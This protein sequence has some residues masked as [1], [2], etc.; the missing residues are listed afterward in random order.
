VRWPGAGSWAIPDKVRTDGTAVGTPLLKELRAI[1]VGRLGAT[2]ESLAAVRCEVPEHEPVGAGS[3]AGMDAT[4]KATLRCSTRRQRPV[5][6][7]P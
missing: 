5:A 2:E 6:G 7:T 3:E 1:L 4:W